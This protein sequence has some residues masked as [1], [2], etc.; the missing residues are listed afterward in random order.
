MRPKT[1][2]RKMQIKNPNLYRDTLTDQVVQYFGNATTI[3]NDE[4]I[5]CV[6]YMPYNGGDFRIPNQYFVIPSTDF[7]KNFEKYDETVT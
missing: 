4:Y 7:L 1:A 6:M 2:D 3:I 5:N